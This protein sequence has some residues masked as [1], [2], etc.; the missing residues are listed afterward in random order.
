VVAFN[1]EVPPL[2]GAPVQKSISV[3]RSVA[4]HLNQAVSANPSNERMVVGV[5]DGTANPE[6]MAS[7]HIHKFPSMFVLNSK[8]EEAFYLPEALRDALLEANP[9]ESAQTQTMVK[10][11]L[12]SILNGQATAEKFHWY[13]KIAAILRKFPPLGFLYTYVGVGDLEFSAI[14]LMLVVT[15]LLLFVVAK[16]GGDDLAPNAQRRRPPQSPPQG[17]AAAKKE[18]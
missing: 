1:G 12:D 8:V 15:P 14:S 10:S 3:L 16:T 5:L 13:G 17:S 7:V 18:Q 2:N 4:Q 9:W 11:W 6:F